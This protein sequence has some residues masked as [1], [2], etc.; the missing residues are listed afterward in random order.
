MLKWIGIFDFSVSFRFSELMQRVFKYGDIQ[1]TVLLLIKSW[2]FWCI[3]RLPTSLYTG[4]I[5]FQKWSSFLAH[6]AHAAVLSRQ[7]S[8]SRTTA[9]NFTNH[10]V[11]PHGECRHIIE[12]F[13][14]FIASV[15]V[16]RWSLK[17]LCTALQC[18]EEYTDENNLPIRRNSEK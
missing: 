13:D 16:Q 6:P 8:S 9:A 12:W 17:L 5:L 4:V 11:A 18:A 10:A 7:R 15:D 14:K 1:I 3:E 2:T